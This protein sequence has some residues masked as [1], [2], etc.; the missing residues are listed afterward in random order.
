MESTP[1]N[2]VK[3]LQ[4]CLV[5]QLALGDAIILRREIAEPLLSMGHGVTILCNANNKFVFN[6]FDCVVEDWPLSRRRFYSLRQFFNIVRDISVSPHTIVWI[7][8][9]HFLEKIYSYIKFRKYKNI[10]T[11]NLRKGLRRRLNNQIVGNL[12]HFSNDI[13]IHSFDSYG[14]HVE[15]FVQAYQDLDETYDFKRVFKNKLH[16]FLIRKNIEKVYIQISALVAQKSMS[17]DFVD[18]L[19][20]SCASYSLFLISDSEPTGY[21]NVGAIHIYPKDVRGQIGNG[22]S[23]LFLLDSFLLHSLAPGT[24]NYI[25]MYVAQ[26]YAYDW[27]PRKV[28]SISSPYSLFY[29]I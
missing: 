13:D 19:I 25:F 27:L 7:P 6:G 14:A 17:Q 12:I 23:L 8:S 21:S 2:A 5:S 9:G 15:F 16:K 28:T 22:D 4:F 24:E 18:L 10:R 3:K 20:E 26:I 29:R 1:T 11:A